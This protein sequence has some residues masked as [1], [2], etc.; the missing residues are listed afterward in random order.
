MVQ[1]LRTSTESARSYVH[2]QNNVQNTYNCDVSLARPAFD[3]TKVDIRRVQRALELLQRRGKRRKIGSY[4][5]FKSMVLQPEWSGWK[6]AY[7]RVEGRTTSDEIEQQQQQQSETGVREQQSEQ[8]QRSIFTSKPS[9][10]GRQRPKT[11]GVIRRPTDVGVGMP[12]GRGSM[13]VNEMNIERKEIDSGDL[14]R[15]FDKLGVSMNLNEAQ[16]LVDLV[17]ENGKGTICAKEFDRLVYSPSA[18]LP[19]CEKTTE[20]NRIKD[21]L[22]R[23]RIKQNLLS[24]AFLKVDPTREYRIN[25]EAFRAA[26]GHIIPGDQH[27]VEELWDVA[28]EKRKDSKV[29]WRD[30]CYDVINYSK[31]RQP[32]TPV[33]LQSP[34][35]EYHAKVEAEEMMSRPWSNVNPGL[36][37]PKSAGARVS[38]RGGYDGSHLPSKHNPLMAATTS[39][40]HHVPEYD[41]HTHHKPHPLL[42]TR[43][44]PA[45]TAFGRRSEQNTKR[46]WPE[47]VINWE[48]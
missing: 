17:D 42:V 29:D 38:S 37:R 7:D 22:K 40:F 5:S 3:K 1:L 30:L 41:A 10:K 46:L 33:A 16:H 28:T 12:D 2:V 36:R 43:S 15:F 18:K 32:D 45:R 48:R 24:N 27:L 19:F 35:H 11:A 44:Q 23:V 26:M 34:K 21:I 47:R 20:D 9:N 39:G 8:Q 13:K 14:T 4:A 25:K 6:K 31:T